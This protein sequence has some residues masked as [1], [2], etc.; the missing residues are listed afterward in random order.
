MIYINKPTEPNTNVTIIVPF[1]KNFEKS[2]LYKTI[3]DG[4][5]S[6]SVY[7]GEVANGG[8]AFTEV[9]DYVAHGG[10]AYM[11]AEYLDASMTH[12][13]SGKAYK[14]QNIEPSRFEEDFYFTFMLHFDDIPNRGE[15]NFT[16][17]SGDEVVWNGILKVTDNVRNDVDFNNGLI[18][19]IY[20]K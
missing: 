12:K 5:D 3:L 8:G 11:G 13:M 1:G 10:F 17:K 9:F 4:G 16:V 7:G 2:S 20:E 6:V 18:I 15:Y 14:W 19:K